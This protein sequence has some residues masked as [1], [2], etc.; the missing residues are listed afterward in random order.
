MAYVY[1]IVATI[2]WGVWGFADKEALARANIWHVLLG[3]SGPFLVMI[4]V[5][6]VL[7]RRTSPETQ[8]NRVALGWSVLAS[9]ASLAATL[10]VFFSMRSKPASVAVGATSAFPL[11]TL[12]LGVWC[13]TE[14]FS[15]PRFVGLIL[16]AAGTALLTL[17]K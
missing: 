15:L 9:V 3:Y 12:A 17:R 1:L 2:L 10:C 6:Y 11:V 7:W 14:V 8:L 4:P 5:W 13:G 16:I